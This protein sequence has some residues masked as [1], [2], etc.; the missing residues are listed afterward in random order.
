[1]FRKITLSV[2]LFLNIIVASGQEISDNIVPLLTLKITKATSPEGYGKTLLH[3]IEAGTFTDLNNILMNSMK[4]KNT[5]LWPDGEQLDMSRRGTAR[6]ETGGILD[7]YTIVHSNKKDTIQLYVNP[8]K[9][10][11]IYLPAG[12]AFPRGKSFAPLIQP[13]LKLIEEI[14]DLPDSFADSIAKQKQLRVF[15]F[16]Q[17][18]VG[19]SFFYDDEIIKHLSKDKSISIDVAGYLFRAYLFNSFLAYA[20]GYGNEKS[21]GLK[22]M[23]EAYQR[24]VNQF[25][26]KAN[27]G[28]WE[29]LA[30]K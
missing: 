30:E 11:E 1:M 27:E 18:S 13:F 22:K 14:N 21:Y 5:F 15:I 12:L 24:M 29:W 25:P 3:P 28:L 19:L 26:E 10:G 17:N 4:F 6:S 16:L 7:H 23:K 20:R 9:M 8:Y 2:Y